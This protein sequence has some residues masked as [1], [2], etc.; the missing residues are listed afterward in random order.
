META[1]KPTE[2]QIQNT[3]QVRQKRLAD[4]LMKKPINRRVREG[5][6]EAV[7]ILVE[8]RETYEGIDDT[9]DSVQTRAIAVLAV[10]YINGEAEHKVLVNLPLVISK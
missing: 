5:Y 1:T 10:D 6:T 3:I 8:G 7:N 2:A 9:L 4:P